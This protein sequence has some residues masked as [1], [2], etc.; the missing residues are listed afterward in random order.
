[1]GCQS[2]SLSYWQQTDSLWKVVPKKNRHF[3]QC[4]STST[5]PSSFGH[6]TRST[7]LIGI[8]LYS[9]DIEIRNRIRADYLSLAVQKSL[10][11]A[12]SKVD[13]EYV[14]YFEFYKSLI[15]KFPIV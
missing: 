2:L 12:Y 7:T 5:I 8:I 6:L 9:I 4:K 10:D 15:F 11:V 13:E 3:L 1:M 14:C